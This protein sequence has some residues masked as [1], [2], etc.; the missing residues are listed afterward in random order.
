MHDALCALPEMPFH[1]A[2]PEVPFHNTL[3]HNAFPHDAPLKVALHQ[4]I[5]P[6]M[7]LFKMTSNYS[8]PMT[9]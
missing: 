8:T 3:S 4:Q 2:L 7:P 9:M 1:N 6:K 5:Y